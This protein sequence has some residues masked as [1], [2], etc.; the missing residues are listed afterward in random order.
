MANSTLTLA[1]SRLLAKKLSDSL[2][3]VAADEAPRRFVADAFVRILCRPPT[4]DEAGDL[5]RVSR[6]AGGQAGRPEVADRIF[7]RP[8]RERCRRRPIP[9][10]ERARTWCTC[11]SITTTL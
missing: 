10:S 8:C 3:N 2:G 9:R 4:D 7:S 11:C 5:P 1:Q 6:R